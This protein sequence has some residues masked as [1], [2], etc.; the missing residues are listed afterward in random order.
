[1]KEKTALFLLRYRDDPSKII[2]IKGPAFIIGRDKKCDLVLS[3]RKVSRRHAMLIVKEKVPFIFDLNS[4]NGTFL[5]NKIITECRLRP[6]DIIKIGDISFIFDSPQKQLP[7]KE[8]DTAAIESSKDNDTERCIFRTK[9][10]SSVKLSSLFSNGGDTQVTNKRLILA[11]RISEIVINEIDLKTVLEKALDAI[12]VTMEIDRVML[13]LFNK[14]KKRLEP[15]IIKD[16]DSTKAP[17]GIPVS[18]RIITECLKNGMAL[19]SYDAAEDPRFVGS[20][21]IILHQIHSTIYVPL[22]YRDELL[23]LFNVDVIRPNTHLTEDDLE[24]FAGIGNTLALA[25]KNHQLLQERLKAQRLLAIG[26]T[27]AGLSHDIK[28]MLTVLM[29]AQNVIEQAIVKGDLNLITKGWQPLKLANQKMLSWV[30]NLI[31]FSSAS[32]LAKEAVN[33]K[34]ILRDIQRIFEEPSKKLGIRLVCESALD[35]LKACL[36]DREKIFQVIFNL[37]TNALDATHG[38]GDLVKIICKKNENKK[39]IIFSVM[40]NGVGL[41]GVNIEKLFDP[42]YSTKKGKGTGLGLALAKKIVEEHEGTITVQPNTPKGAIFTIF[43]P[44]Q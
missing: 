33:P 44:C 29:S 19:L 5:N 35:N 24:F 41:T 42:F 22:I 13:H 40:D 3:D 36:I 37:V 8:D 31:A 11:N 10:V 16:G 26:E 21:S 12:Y 27:M 18:R 43:L 14:E 2:K 28:N 38:H 7:E 17:K 34:D 6:G 4:T 23:G 32:R 20:E 30:R 39:G 9:K 25:I 15:Y 1:M